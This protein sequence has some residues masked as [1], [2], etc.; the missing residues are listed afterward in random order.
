MMDCS[1]KAC[2]GKDKLL[3]K[4]WRR[5]C[6]I[7]VWRTP[8][9]V[10]IAVIVFG[11]FTM[12]TAQVQVSQRAAAPPAATSSVRYGGGQQFR[13]NTRLLPS[14]QRY[15]RSA[16]GLL[17][18]EMRHV[19][20]SSGALPSQGRL[21]PAASGG[22]ALR[23]PTYSR[24]ARATRNNMNM[25]SIRYQNYYTQPTRRSTAPLTMNV[26]RRSKT[27]LTPYRLKFPDRVPPSLRYGS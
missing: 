13:H 26:P 5:L 9:V 6:C 19:R 11:S 14:E 23:Y 25:P 7:S 1:E 15:V 10:L 8:V 17:P 4:Q 16:S 24:H 22:A 12:I 27:T 20:M 18:S 3:R 21:T 2:G